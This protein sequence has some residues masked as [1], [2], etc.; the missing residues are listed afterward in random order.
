MGLREGGTG[1]KH[2]GSKPDG[3]ALVVHRQENRT[4]FE[5]RPHSW[6]IMMMLKEMPKETYLLY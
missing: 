6:H 5:K 2:Q 3:L 1:R 4:I